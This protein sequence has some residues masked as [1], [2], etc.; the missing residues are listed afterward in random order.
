MRIK[1]LTL[2]LLVLLFL[3]SHSRAEDL[4]KLVSLSGY[5]KFTIG[6]DSRW[7]GPSF[8]DSGWDQIRVPN[9]WENEGYNEYNGYAWYRKTFKLPDVPLDK[10]LY[11]IVGKIDDVDEVYV[12]GKLVGG[13]GGFPPSFETSYSKLR[14]YHLPVEYLKISGVNVIA[15]KVYDTFSEGGIKDGPVGIYMN[16]DDEFLD[17]DLS[18]KWKFS[19]G[20]N[21]TW[22]TVD[23]DDRNWKDINVPSEWELE[24]YTAYDGYAW[25]RKKFKL[26]PGYDTEN[27]YLS[28]GKIDDEDDV[29]LNGTHIGSVF[30]LRKDGEY[31]R[32]GYEYNARRVYKIPAHLFSAN[33]INVISIR[34][35]DNQQRGG[36][37]EGPIGIMTKENYRKYMNKYHSNQSFWDYIFEEFIDY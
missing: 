30:Q 7:S 14:K 29:Y 8:D 16:A 6:D 34:V 37:Y 2:N 23:F 36:I 1:L 9:S 18:G 11:L 26:P 21:K 4:K 25:Y 20:E 3:V 31:R 33:G 17:I 13:S 12:N 10:K 35:Y 19:T 24:G 5:W 28:V 27:L 22:R 15:V 32:A